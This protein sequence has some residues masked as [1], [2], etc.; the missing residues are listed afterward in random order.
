MA[1]RR[2]LRHGK[3]SIRQIDPGHERTRSAVGITAYGVPETNWAV[4]HTDRVSR[5]RAHSPQVVEDLHVRKYR[6]QCLAEYWDTSTANGKL[7]LPMILAFYP[8]WGNSIREQSID[9]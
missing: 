7:Q 5:G 8:W 9:C 2:L 1:G 3:Y 4:T 6:I